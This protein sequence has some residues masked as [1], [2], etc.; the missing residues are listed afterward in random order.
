MRILGTAVALGLWAAA[1]WLAWFS[2]DRVNLDI[3]DGVNHAVAAKPELWQVIGSAFSIAT[4]AALAYVWLRREWIGGSTA[5]IA[6]LATAGPIGFVMP[7]AWNQANDPTADGLF[8]IG[9][10]LIFVYGATALALLLGVIEVAAR[11]RQSRP[12]GRR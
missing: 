12:G 1:M 4:I 8:V 9:A 10:V 5:S 6:M 3:G 11:S 7:W 2:W